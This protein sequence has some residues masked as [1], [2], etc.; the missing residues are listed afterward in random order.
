MTVLVHDQSHT[1]VA[2]AKVTGT[3]SAGDTNK[4]TLSCTTNASGQCNVTSGRLSRATNASVTFSVTNLTAAGATYQS[5]ANHDADGS[6][7]GTTV[8]VP[9]P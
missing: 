4:R 1:P 6:S 5:S 7:N 9:R 2:N 3:W 8:T